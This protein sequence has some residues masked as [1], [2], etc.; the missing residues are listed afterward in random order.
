MR[1]TYKYRLYPSRA[2]CSMLNSI[3]G[4]CCWVYN[5]VLEVRRNAWRGQGEFITRY[6]TMKMLPGWKKDLEYLNVVYSQ[7]LQEVCTRVDLAFQSFFRNVK[8]GGPPGYPR[9]HNCKDYSSFTFPQ[10]NRGF[11]IV[12]GDTLHLSKVGDIKIKLHRPIDGTVKTLTVKRDYLGNWWACFSCEAECKFLAPASSMVGIDLGLTY[13]ATL[14]TGEHVPNPRFFREEEMV[15]AK[16]QRR[17]SKCTKGTTE[18]CK[19][20][21]VVQHIHNRI[22]NR[23]RDFVHKLS[24]RLVNDFQIIVFE[25]LSIQGMQRNN[26][27]NI[28]KGIG[29]AAWGELVKLTQEK[30]ERTGRVVIKVDP[31]NTSQMCSS[32]GQIVPKDLSIRVHSC[33]FCGLSLD[34]DENAA[35]NILARGLACLGRESATKISSLR[36]GEQPQCVL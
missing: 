16:A 7:V 15:L 14:S 33:S 35:R 21:R 27:R 31:R 25:D 11:K 32:C 2:Q 28:N 18:Y 3:L 5:K 26:W 17:F 6:D 23:R 34:R 19:N 20:R 36:R 13:F 12:D 1:I 4:A 8:T 24:R 30:A 29:D 9:F 10:R 22:V